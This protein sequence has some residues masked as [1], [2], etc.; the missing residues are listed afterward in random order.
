MK[1]EQRTIARLKPYEYN[2]RLHSPEQIEKLKAS[3]QEFGW[4]VPIL[5]NKQG[6]VIAGHGRLEAAKALGYKTVPVIRHDTLT[7]EQ[8]QAYRLADN[9][10]TEMGEWDMAKLEAELASLQEANFDL[11]VTGFDL[12]HF[13]HP[14]AE[15]SLEDQGRLDKKS[16]TIC[17]ECGHEF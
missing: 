13:N 5:I 12:K 9:R 14:T 17:P 6:V 16:L 1:I 7:K 2:A 15:G 3:L 4:M 11:D 8:E 10:I